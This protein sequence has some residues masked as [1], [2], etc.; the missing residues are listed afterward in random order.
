MSLFDEISSSPVTTPAAFH[1]KP[2]PSSRYVS[3]MGILA[4]VP[5]FQATQKLARL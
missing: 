4:Y 3:S 2:L 1:M 5:L